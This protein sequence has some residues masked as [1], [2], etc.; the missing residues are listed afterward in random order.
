MAAAL[1][2][3]ALA[4]GLAACSSGE[5]E[6]KGSSSDAESR[7]EAEEK[8]ARDLARGDCSFDSEL[9]LDVYVLRSFERGPEHLGSTLS[10]E[11]LEVPHCLA[12]WVQ[13]V[14]EV[15]MARLREEIEAKDIPAVALP[16]ATDADLAHLEGLSHLVTLLLDGTKVTD[17]GLVHL[18]GLSGLGG[19]GLSSTAVTD[20][21]LAHLAKLKG[22][23][24]LWLSGTKVTDAGLAHLEGLTRLQELHLRGTGVTDPG[25]ER[26]REALPD[27]KIV[28]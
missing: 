18:E 24:Y 6:E 15:D 20:A 28:H 11:P 10:E 4:I 1:A 7:E 8:A 13:P 2:A 27:T 19:L 12:W 23:H 3:A 25:V 26:L 9:P 16:D 22:L 14:G 5:Q 21:G 17:A